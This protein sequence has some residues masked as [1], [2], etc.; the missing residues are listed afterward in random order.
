M[1]APHGR[2]C[3][4]CKWWFEAGECRRLPPQMVLWPSDNQHPI[5]YMPSA[6]WPNVKPDDWC[7]EWAS[8]A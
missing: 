2:V 6:S 4:G 8:A 5:M 3:L 1:T 7:G